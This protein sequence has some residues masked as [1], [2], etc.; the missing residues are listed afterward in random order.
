MGSY[1][2]VVSVDSGYRPPGEVGAHGN[3]RY[4]LAAFYRRPGE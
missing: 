2:A 3:E 1:R 4:L